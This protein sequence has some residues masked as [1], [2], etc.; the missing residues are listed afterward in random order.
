MPIE[1]SQ[2]FVRSDVTT[3]WYQETLSEEHRQH[4]TDTYTT[5]GKRTGAV[6]ISEDGTMMTIFHRFRDQ[7]AL[8]EF[9]TDPI[10]MEMKD[11]RDVYNTEHGIYSLT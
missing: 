8:Q 5:P 4:M 9:S 2:I 7:E 10:I 1:F 6:E 3:P 11:N